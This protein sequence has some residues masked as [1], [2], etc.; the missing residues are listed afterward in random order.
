MISNLAELKTVAVTLS[1]EYNN[2]Y[3]FVG[4]GALQQQ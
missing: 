4:G 1:K 3:Y 2:L